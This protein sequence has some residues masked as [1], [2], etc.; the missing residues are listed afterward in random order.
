M[1][2]VR[3]IHFQRLEQYQALEN[4]G[5][6]I[7]SAYP[8]TTKNN[9]QWPTTGLRLQSLR[10]QGQLQKVRRLHEEAKVRR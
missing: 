8:K 7:M 4:V 9:V 10:L 5:Y 2:Y 1:L 6:A 3:H